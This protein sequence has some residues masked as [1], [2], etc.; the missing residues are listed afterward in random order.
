MKNTTIDG[1]N[2]QELLEAA[3]EGQAAV[4]ASDERAEPGTIVGEVL[5]TH[6]PHFPGRVFVRW[7][8]T[9]KQAVEHWVQ[10]E[11]HLS[12]VKG[13]RV[14]M[15]LPMGWKQWIVTGAL[16]RARTTPIADT[17]NVSHL[18][19]GPGESLR[20]LS[21]DGQPLVTVSQGA[22]GPV[23]EL[24]SGNVELKAARTLRLVADTI[25]L[26][27]ANGGIDLRTEGDAVVRAR[28]IRLN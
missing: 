5:D 15:T 3:L 2:L 26:K 11:R 21:H 6:H 8:N 27:A 18:Q 23:V 17:E 22:E 1:R 13:D 7:L 25:E 19:L 4:E 14:L 9:A 12:L 28:T 10:A 24:G 20:V 16:G